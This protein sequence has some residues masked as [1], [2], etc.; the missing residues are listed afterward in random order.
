M[1]FFVLLIVMFSIACKEIP[2]SKK[3]PQV[4]EI[5][6]KHPSGHIVKYPVDFDTFWHPYNHRGGVFRFKTTDGR[7]VRS[8]FCHG[9]AI[10]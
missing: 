10:H 6:C 7:I 3:D 1:K 2:S 8:S 4:Y 9:E 5:I